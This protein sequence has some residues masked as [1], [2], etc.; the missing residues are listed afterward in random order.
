MIS[1]PSTVRRK[2]WTSRTTC[3][4]CGRCGTVLNLTGN[5][6]GCGHRRLRGLHRAGRR[7]PVRIVLYPASAVGES[8]VT[9]IE[10]LAAA[11]R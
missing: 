4:C 2:T 6:Y 10:G 1:S 5:K 3:P 9:T 8:Q 11:A 7:Q